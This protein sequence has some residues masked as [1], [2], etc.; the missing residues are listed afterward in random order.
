MGYVIPHPHMLNDQI[1]D[2]LESR[3]KLYTSLWFAT[4]TSATYN[5]QFTAILFEIF[6]IKN[7][8][9]YDPM[10]EK[11]LDIP[12]CPGAG[13]SFPRSSS[14]VLCYCGRRFN[15][16]FDSIKDAWQIPLHSPSCNNKRRRRIYHVAPIQET[17]KA[18]THQISFLH[19]R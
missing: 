10:H 13:V 3:L 18:W 11:V 6:K 1:Y 7:S 14:S 4:L 12:I 5:L 8:H 16:R 2:V 15:R 19:F 9:G 17:S